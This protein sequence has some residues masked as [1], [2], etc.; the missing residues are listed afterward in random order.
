MEKT[1]TRHAVDL[2]INGN[3][4]TMV[5]IGRHY[6]LKHGASVNDALILELLSA[7]DGHKFPID[8]TTDGVDYYVADVET[9]PDAKTYRLIWLFEGE[10]LEVLGVVNAYR[11]KGK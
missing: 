8:S 9:A 6:L 7:L 11:R 3:H 10:K 4:I 5:L 2:T 1:P